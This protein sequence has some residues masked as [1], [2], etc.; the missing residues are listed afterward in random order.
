M[1]ES[2]CGTKHPPHLLLNTHTHAHPRTLLVHKGSARRTKLITV[3][4]RA[5]VLMER[6]MSGLTA[7]AERN[8]AS[9]VFSS[10]PTTPPIAY[11]LIL[12]TLKRYW[13]RYPMSAV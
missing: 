5:A 3:K 8:D 7:G 1:N 10:P 13:V 2:L 4:H 12:I 6:I 9:T 11:V